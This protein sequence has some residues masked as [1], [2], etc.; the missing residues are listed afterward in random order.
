M[1]CIVIEPVLGWWRF[2]QIFWK[3]WRRGAGGAGHAN[4][5]AGGA[6]AHDLL[7]HAGVRHAGLVVLPPGAAFLAALGQ[8]LQH[9]T[10][11]AERTLPPRW[12]QGA[13]RRR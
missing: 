5:R 13:C 10:V 7:P 1:S 2:V 8:W 6:Q 4:G 11:T 12:L 3:S 9:W